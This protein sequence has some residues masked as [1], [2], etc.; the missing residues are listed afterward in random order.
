MKKWTLILLGVVFTNASALNYSDG[1]EK[2]P[3]IF[4]SN[5]YHKNNNN[6]LKLA[7]TL[8]DRGGIDSIYQY[9]FLL[10]ELGYNKKALK[11][12]KLAA[13]MGSSDA[14]FML[15]EWAARSNNIKLT[16]YHFLKAAEGGHE[17]ASYIIGINFYKN[18]DGKEKGVEWL[19]KAA[20]YGNTNAMV[21]LYDYY[22][23]LNKYKAINY[24]IR[25]VDGGNIIANYKYAKNLLSSGKKNNYPL[26][27]ELLKLGATQG[28]LMSEF[29]LGKLFY[30]VGNKN[31]IEYLISADE[32]GHPLASYYLGLIYEHG[33]WV[34]GD[35]QVSL[36]YYKKAGKAGY[37]NAITK[38]MDYYQQGLYGVVINNAKALEWGLKSARLGDPWSQFNVGVMFLGEDGVKMDLINAKKWLVKAKRQGVTD[39]VKGLLVLESIIGGSKNSAKIYNN[40]GY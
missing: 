8:A 31:S 20:G 21:I 18:G 30:E 32:K 26:V 38:V 34:A 36:N 19:K 9:G 11:Q 17:F 3:T 22:L 28:H 1:S 35:G 15:G 13:E 6:S 33:K 12:Y 40:M 10:E 39:A 14:Y 23:P 5:Y 29:E 25:A 2:D 16:N 4:L 27:I 37:V 7:Q 24:I